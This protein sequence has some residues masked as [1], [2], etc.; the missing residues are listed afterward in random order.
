MLD[1]EELKEFGKKIKDGAK[2]HYDTTKDMLNDVREL[3]NKLDK[4]TIVKAYK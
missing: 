4:I 1:D 3:K 2:N